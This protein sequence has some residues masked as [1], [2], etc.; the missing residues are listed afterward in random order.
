VVGA[1]IWYGPGVGGAGSD[2]HVA[3]V[4]SIYRD[5]SVLD[6]GYNMLPNP[7]QAYDTRRI[8]AAS[9]SAYLYIPGGAKP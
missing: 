3:V 4:K 1:I 6:E 7:D 5:G 8:P 2:G 9:P